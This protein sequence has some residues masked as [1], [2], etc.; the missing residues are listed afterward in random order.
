M[1]L[2]ALTDSEREVIRQCV[3][4]LRDGRFLDESDIESRVGLSADAY[5]RLRAQWPDLDDR[6]DDSEA[7][8]LV[9]N[10]LNE[11]S[12]GVRLSDADW[13]R[14]FTVPRAQVAQVYRRWAN[15][16]GWER[17]GIR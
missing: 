17:T 6:D 1:S 3:V 13:A 16:R 12:H 2:A 9:N 4:A 5:D 8:L 14:W 7:C 11:V 10:A 15:G